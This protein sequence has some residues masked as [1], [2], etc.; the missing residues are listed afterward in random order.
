MDTTSGRRRYLVLGICCMS[1]FIVS[2][3]NTIVNVALP[4]IG[5]DLHTELSG[6]QWTVDAYT[7][8]LATLL[9]LGGSTADRVG[10]KR[11]FQIGL[12]VFALGSLLCGFAPGLG[13][14]VAF[15][16]VQAIGGSMLNPVAM[17]IIT[18][19]FTDPKERARAI[20][21]W[22]GVI[23][24][25]M[26]LGPVLGGFLVDAVG[27]QA[28][29]WINVPVGMIALVLTRLF[30]P[31][32]RS[33]HP[34]RLDPVGQLLVLVAVFCLT[35]AIIE[36]DNAGW[37][38]PEIIGGFVLA[39]LALAGL[40]LYE[41]RRRQPLLELGFFRS[42]PFS[43]AIVIAVCAFGALAGFLFLNTV[44]LQE[45]RGFSPL[46]A[47]LLT[48]PIAVMVAVGAPV[49]GRL[50]AAYGARISL[51]VS[52]IGIAISG[53]LFT[54]LDNDTAVARILI[55]YVVFGI[56]FGIVNAPIT[57]TAM[58]GMPRSQAG[59]A[60]ALAS[61][62]RQLGGS[63]GIAII[64]TAVTTGIAGGLKT[65]FSA[66]SHTGWWIITGC[67]VMVFVLGLLTT[68][69]WAHATAA[70]RADL[71]AASPS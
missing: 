2:L 63:L 30:V 56:G 4:S 64:G 8:V 62:S 24:L 21:I 48:L 39:A 18:N 49:S 69:R 67:G 55:A 10:R 57:D 46:H 42:A 12:A 52:G 1:L 32:S 29:F 70:R 43:G 66:A 31:E 15:R 13:W 27:W 33:P 38:A 22:G 61:A 3:D 9:M 5:R 26:A 44:Y 45:V 6:L 47:G 34:R 51:V 28:I 37:T 50:V 14:L 65:G 53:L 68:G 58:A 16:G 19:V 20:G 11:V 60:A 54:G 17:S 71:I 36:G 23:G 40:L 7:L 35:Y 25:A 41:P 59:V